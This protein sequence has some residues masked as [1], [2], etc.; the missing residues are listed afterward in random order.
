MTSSA[1]HDCCC[2]MQPRVH[3]GLLAATYSPCIILLLLL[4]VPVPVPVPV[5]ASRSDEV[6]I[7]L[8][9]IHPQYPYLCCLCSAC[10][11]VVPVLLRFLGGG[12]SKRYT[13][14][15]YTRAFTKYIPCTVIL[16][17]LYF[18]PVVAT[19]RLAR[20]LIIISYSARSSK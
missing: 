4:R 5:L 14:F 9:Y 13:L 8:S 20:S 17:C 6:P 18:T 1:R 2:R 16:A 15:N 3:G 10:V 11:D 7:I 19:G 12:F